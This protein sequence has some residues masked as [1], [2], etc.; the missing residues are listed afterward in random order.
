[1]QNRHFLWF[2]IPDCFISNKVS[3][4]GSRNGLSFANGNVDWTFSLKTKKTF[5]TFFQKLFEV[6]PQFMRFYISNLARVLLKV[7]IMIDSCPYNNIFTDDL[8]NSPFNSNVVQSFVCGT[9][10][11]KKM[12]FDKFNW[13]ISWIIFVVSILSFKKMNFY[14]QMVTLKLCYIHSQKI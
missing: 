5:Q 4:K 12:S 6:L 9:R 7:K 1:M 2:K 10:L 8:R 11:C 13:I 3:L 14:F